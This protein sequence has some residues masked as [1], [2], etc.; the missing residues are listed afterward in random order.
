MSLLLS[1][2]SRLFK[3]EGTN[4]NPNI[5]LM[6][7]M[8]VI[9]ISAHHML[10][11]I[12]DP[13]IPFI[14]E[15][16]YFNG[17]PNVFKYTMRFL[18]V[19]CSVLLLFNIRV[20]TTSM[21]IGLVVIINIIASKP[22]FYNHLLICGCA[23]FL[24]GL[25]NN[26][27]PAKLLIYQLSIVYFGASLN[28]FLDPD[29]WSGQF[30]HN[31]LGVAR[32]NPPYLY[33]SQYFKD[34]MFAKSLSYI[35]MFT[36]FIIAVLILFRR[37]RHMTILFIII[38]HV[39]LFTI[40]SFRF[41]HFIESL[42]IVLLAFLSIPSKKHAITYR[43]NTMNYVK[44][45]FQLFDLDKKQIWSKSTA[46]NDVWLSL[47]ISNNVY[48][49]HSALKKIIVYTPNFYMFLLFSDMAFYIILYNH[50]T[51]L[52]L[53]NVIFVWL[54]IFYLLPFKQDKELSI[55]ND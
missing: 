36:E 55:P 45:L 43:G 12:S 28:K 25:T 39:T 47:K 8:L 17:Y 31:W 23:L 46:T 14:Q 27:T 21:I 24:A 40:T 49:N 52:F 42:A 48:L 6:C 30:M 35:A 51:L 53:L 20:K 22:L 19:S 2:S 11:K 44:Q 37:T 1:F 10:F 7:K 33:I 13:F 41:G 15:F 50:R 29:W 54:L 18:Y 5:L 4:L 16:D 3:F 26:K 9:L 32:E 38:F 34:L